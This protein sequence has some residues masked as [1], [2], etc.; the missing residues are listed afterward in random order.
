MSPEELEPVREALS[1][2]HRALTVNTSKAEMEQIAI[3][4]KFQLA[5]VTKA[6]GEGK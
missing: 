5:K 2:A 1:M 3:W 4:V 6:I